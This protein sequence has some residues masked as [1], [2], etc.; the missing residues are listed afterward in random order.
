MHQQNFDFGLGYLEPAVPSVNKATDFCE[1]IENRIYFYSEVKRE[2][3]LKLNK[4]LRIAANRII[5]QSIN[6]STD[7]GTQRIWLHINSHGGLIFDGLSA[8][9]EIMKCKI[10]VYTI[11]DGCCASAGTFLSVVG[12]RR[13]INKN[14]FILIHQLTSS[15][16]GKYA[17]MKDEKRNL[18][19]FMLTI[20]NIYTTHTKISPRKLDELL[21]HDLWYNAEEALKFGLV[22]EII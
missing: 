15:F 22:D 7:I 9:D 8:M 2:Q 4:E 20:K 1:I 21:K 13:F 10:P 18:D 6:E 14:A 5:T 17:D 3:V 16:W 11:V 19:R 12:K